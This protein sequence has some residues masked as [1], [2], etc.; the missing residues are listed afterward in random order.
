MTEET[1]TPAA[2]PTPPP[3]TFA[4]LIEIHALQILIFTGKQVDPRTGQPVKN[5]PFARHNLDMLKMIREKTQGNL[6]EE[7][8]RVLEQ[9][10]NLAQMAYDEA[11]QSGEGDAAPGPA[12][13]AAGPEGE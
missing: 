8:Q 10:Q 9:Y 13:E 6:D 7:E 4:T 5:L 3:A 1:P 11:M 2:G 12:N